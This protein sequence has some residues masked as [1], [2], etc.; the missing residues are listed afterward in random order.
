[1]TE[2]YLPCPKC[3]C[4][5]ATCAN[6]VGFYDSFSKAADE[7]L[8]LGHQQ[9]RKAIANCDAAIYPSDWAANSAINDY[10]AAP[11]KVHVVP[12]GANVTAH[13]PQVVHDW[14]TA[15]PFDVMRVL[16]I[17]R[18]WKRKGGETV[19]RACEILRRHKVK[20]R[21]DVVGI[22]ACPVALPQ[23]AT[24]HGDRKST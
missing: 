14:I 21:L 23:Y 4:A 1:M 16:F 17:G 19:L 8:A 18:D 7:Y 22:P 12:F 9:E 15:R 3:F 13:D 20:L 11:E 10:G 6:V 5:D 24:N 2:L